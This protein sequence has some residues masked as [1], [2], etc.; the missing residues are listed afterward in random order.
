MNDQILSVKHS[1]TKQYHSLNDQQDANNPERV[2]NVTKKVIKTPMTPTP[3]YIV[4]SFPFN[5]P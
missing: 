2:V 4:L 5:H 3:L 1:L